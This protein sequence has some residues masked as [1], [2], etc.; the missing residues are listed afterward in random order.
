MPSPCVFAIFYGCGHCS[1]F[2]YRREHNGSLPGWLRAVAVLPSNTLLGLGFQ[3]NAGLQAKYASAI[4]DR[5]Y[6]H[7]APKSGT[8]VRYQADPTRT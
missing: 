5:V 6:E 3:W 7:H 1:P 8:C 4:S 2:T